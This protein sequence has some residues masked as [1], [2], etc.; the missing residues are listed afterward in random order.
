[1]QGQDFNCS[2]M[3]DQ[4]GP[5]SLQAFT[6]GESL[7]GLRKKQRG[8]LGRGRKQGWTQACM[9]HREV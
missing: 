8:L 2:N 5:P 7:F 3:A 4:Q 6:S 1:M 9:C